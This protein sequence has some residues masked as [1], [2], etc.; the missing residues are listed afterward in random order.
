MDRPHRRPQPVSGL[1]HH[2]ARRPRPRHLRRRLGG[3][4]GE[5]EAVNFPIHLSG[6]SFRNSLSSRDGAWA[7]V[8]CL[9]DQKLHKEFVHQRAAFGEETVDDAA[10]ALDPFRVDHP[11]AA[12]P[13]PAE[14]GQ[15]PSS[16]L[17][18]PLSSASARMARRNRR[19]GSDARRKGTRG[20]KGQ[21]SSCGS[22]VAT[23][24]PCAPAPAPARSP[25]D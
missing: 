3:V 16:D 8:P 24:R 18:S 9:L 5:G 22:V 10:A 2:R 7:S 1:G 4:R 17:R 15:L 20:V 14:T 23:T 6:G 25:A 21:V 13:Q 19:R 11:I 12:D